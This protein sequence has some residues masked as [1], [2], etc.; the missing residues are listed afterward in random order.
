MLPKKAGH[1]IGFKANGCERPKAAAC[2]NATA[3]RRPPAFYGLLWIGAN[4]PI[5]D[6]LTDPPV[7]F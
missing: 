5:G 1:G 2:K 3:H 4:F 6:F 7:Y